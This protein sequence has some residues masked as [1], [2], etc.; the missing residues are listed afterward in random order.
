MCRLLT[1]TDEEEV[2]DHMARQKYVS[3]QLTE[4]ARE[5]M[6]RTQ[7][8]VSAAVGRRL[9][10]SAV[11]LAVYAVAERHQDEVIQLLTEPNGGTTS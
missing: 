11:A 3:M 7:L 5:Q 4:P 6:Q 10:M 1:N 8:N 9:T 2:P